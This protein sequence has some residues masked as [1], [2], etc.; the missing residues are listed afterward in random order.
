MLKIYTM[1]IRKIAFDL[2][3]RYDYVA[4]NF[5]EIKSLYFI[6]PLTLTVIM[7]TN[8]EILQD[9]QELKRIL[10]I[11]E[12]NYIIENELKVNT[13]PTNLVVYKK[14]K[15]T[16]Q[17]LED[18]IGT[19]VLSKDVDLLTVWYEKISDVI[20][21]V[22][23][24][25]LEIFYTLASI[26]LNYVAKGIYTIVHI[27]KHVFEKT[28]FV[29][30]K[31]WIYN[32][33]SLIIPTEPVYIEAPG[34]TI[35]CEGFT[36]DNKYTFFEDG[37]IFYKPK[38]YYHKVGEK[39]LNILDKSIDELINNTNVL[40][41]SVSC[42]KIERLL[43]L[44]NI[45]FNHYA[46]LVN[47]IK[48]DCTTNRRKY[49]F[50]K[51]H[52]SMF[53]FKDYLYKNLSG[54]KTI[55]TKLRETKETLTSI[56]LSTGYVISAD[57]FDENYYPIIA[58]V[59]I[60]FITK[61]EY[62]KLNNFMKVG[63]YKWVINII[64]LNMH[65]ICCKCL[66][67]LSVNKPDEM[68]DDYIKYLE[69]VS[70]YKVLRNWCYSML[71]NSIKQYLIRKNINVY[72]D[73]ISGFDTEYVAEDWGKNKL[74]SA[75]LSI[76]HVIKISIP[77]FLNYNF[78]GVNTLTSETYMKSEPKFNDPDLILSIL[79]H[80]ILETRKYK[81]QMQ[82]DLMYRIASYFL[83][84]KEYKNV[85]VGK[86]NLTVLLDKSNIENIFIKPLKGEDLQINFKSLIKI[87]TKSIDRNFKEKLVLDELKYLD[88]RN[89]GILID[90]NLNRFEKSWDKDT[91]KNNAVEEVSLS[92]EENSV[93]EK[94]KQEKSNFTKSFTLVDKFLQEENLI[95]PASLPDSNKTPI[96]EEEERPTGLILFNK[97]SLKGELGGW[98]KI[99]DDS[100]KTVININVNRRIYLAAHYNAADLTM[101]Q[102]WKNVSLRNIDIAKKCFTSLSLPMKYKG[103]EK[104][105]LRDTILLTSATAKSLEAIAFAYK[106]N[107][108]DVSQYYKENMHLL[109]KEN[110][111]LFKKY[112]M[113]DSIITLVHTLFINDFAFKL[114]SLS[115]PNTLGTLSSKYIKN[116]W[117]NDN[118]RGYQIDVNYPLGD[119]RAS[120][121]PAGIQSGNSTL[122]MSNLY[123][124][125]YRGGRNECFRYGI[126]KSKQWYDY[127][128]VSCYS[129]IMSIM[130]TPNYEKTESERMAAI[131]E[132]I[133]SIMGQPSYEKGQWIDKTTDFDKL[134]F[135]QSYSA[136]RVKF[137]F[138][139][140]LS[141]PPF[142]VT[143][144]KG[145]TIYP[146][147]GETLV[148]GLEY[149][150]GR[151]LLNKIIDRFSLSPKDYFIE[152]LYGSYIPFKTELINDPDNEGKKKEVLAYSPF[153]EVINELQQNRKVWKTLT[154]KGS[155]MERI[156]KDLGNMLYGKIV[157]GI[158]NKKVYDSRTLVMKTMIGN[159]LSNPILGAWITG[160]VRSLIAELLYEVEL[161]GGQV[162]SCT[163]D[164]F[165]CDIENLE[166]KINITPNSL[167]NG[168]KEIRQKL[169]G[170]NLAL[171]VKTFV[172]G[173]TQWTTRGQLSLDDS[174]IPISAM[175]GYQKS[176]NHSENVSLVQ[177][178]LVNGN[179][180][181]FLQK[182]LTGAKDTYLTDKKVSMISQQRSF[183]TI[184]DSKRLVL[185]SDKT[186][187]ETSPFNNV[188]EALIHRTLMSQLKTSVYSDE[189]SVFTIKPSSN[190]IDETVK[191]FIRMITHYYNY[192]TPLYMK[193]NLISFITS[194]EKQVTASYIL[195]LFSSYETDK[196]N[197]V[198]KL[199]VYLRNSEFILNLY[200]LLVEHSTYYEYDNIAKLYLTYFDN[201]IC[202]PRTPAK[203]RD[204]LII[205]L[206]N[207][208]PENLI[209]KEEKGKISI[210]IIE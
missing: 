59:L 149:I 87:I 31:K 150:T 26:S 118:F 125:S 155:A 48:N 62:E 167:I 28:I 137:C 94:V 189:Y 120:H 51:Y 57:I 142:P 103:L 77:L 49:E 190:S 34:K 191:Y 148:T 18:L 169:S 159:D 19:S 205:K 104:V 17:E 71:D 64:I 42:S 76:T 135:K 80:Q 108:V 98:E 43:S 56:N 126:D 208:N 161:L 113:T 209:I 14:R 146:S 102:D 112:A 147:S 130:G 129:S 95:D 33:R 37:N 73:I 25:M 207:I 151:T 79:T 92:N 67:I 187:L 20:I 106:L 210:T 5:K 131:A 203:L 197:V 200:N 122:E 24:D 172:N 100:L 196:G 111:D 32:K 1:L 54:F 12:L 45:S 160:Y 133:M 183:R 97:D 66:Y 15:L 162:V 158:A 170:D 52:L 153:F 69:I 90:A 168:Y 180:I 27:I 83:N 61:D 199:P 30:G 179:K 121:T 177:Q 78:E 154:G 192:N 117:E 70:Q 99:K 85:R 46:K 127:D 23:I 173:I 44:Y 21:N 178:A 35:Y 10:L 157:C 60:D 176:R 139:K 193:N 29:Y 194:L 81:Y 65:T 184:F 185:M 38:I 174:K 88:Y 7:K 124:G 204:D 109:Y 119:A 128:L 68:T 53:L 140:E 145:I 181:L 132:P 144:D 3:R 96:K 39:S 116:K 11:Q 141:Y 195:D 138:P 72:S 91:M 202:L 86:K 201:F 152:I 47:E 84:N 186:M 101:I 75:Q 164:G 22:Y 163:T 136:L 143:L 107:K 198:T 8:N 123:I 82:D 166:E 2:L 105:Y 156:Y 50:N 41:M 165:V 9:L 115:I 114:G 110:Y 58:R 74:L 16:L 93:E 182:E 175:T 63:I 4:I 13:T 134:D 36:I 89:T 40:Y 171:E 6:A 206:Q 55:L 188:S